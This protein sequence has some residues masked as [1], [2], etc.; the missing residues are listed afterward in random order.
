MQSVTVIEDVTEVK[1]TEFE[2]ARLAEDR[3]EVARVLQRGLLP[4]ALPS[5]RDWEAAAM[6]RPAG[7][8][9]EVGGDFYDAFAVGD[10]WMLA[11]GDVVGRGAAAASLTALA[12]HTIRTAGTLT[13]D[14]LVAL[15]LLDDAL[16]E[17]AGQ[18]LCTVAIAL[19]PDG[20]RGRRGPWPGSS[21]PAIRSRLRLR[22]RRGAWRSECPG[23]FWAPSTLR[24]GRSRMS[25]LLR[26]TSS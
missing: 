11:V 26:A 21:A 6:Y 14:P 3:A 7:E 13:Q 20:A 8:V 12:R 16:A 1:R 5:M 22:C 10:G 24:P 19:L 17:R 25:R 15:R 18:A 2:R 23:R 9:N 4:P